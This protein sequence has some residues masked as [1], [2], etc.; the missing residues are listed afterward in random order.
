MKLT[1]LGATGAVRTSKPYVSANP[2]AAH[3]VGHHDPER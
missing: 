3:P 1:I 2:C